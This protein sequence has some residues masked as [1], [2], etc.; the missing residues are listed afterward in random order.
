MTGFA[1]II[2]AYKQTDSAMAVSLMTFVL[3]CLTFLVS[4]LQ[5]HLLTG[6]RKKRQLCW[7]RI[8]PRLCHTIFVWMLLIYGRLDIR[9][10]YVVNAVTG[11][12]NAFQFPAQSVAV[13]MLVPKELYAR[14][15][16]DGFLFFQPADGGDTGAGASISSFWGLEGR[17]SRGS[18]L[19]VLRSVSCSFS[20]GFRRSAA[21]KRRKEKPFAGLKGRDCFP[22]KGKGPG[23]YDFQH[24]V[25]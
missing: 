7:R 19:F 10:I 3:M 8:P 20:S 22:E 5:V 9:Y 21:G 12:M 4:L 11:F 6:T 1:L 25:D 18:W 16:R 24:G 17:N 13:G 23:I 15:K 14:G 2:W